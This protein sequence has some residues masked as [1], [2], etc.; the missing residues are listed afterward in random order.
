MKDGGLKIHSDKAWEIALKY[1]YTLSSDTRT[2]AAHIDAALS[3]AR[4]TGRREGLS[5]AAR[6]HEEVVMQIRYDPD[7]YKNGKMRPS[8]KR[9][10]DLHERS[11]AAIRAAMEK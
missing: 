9:S 4:A 2:L 3:E 8:C 11:A 5:E 6:Y 7:S 1:S 10:S